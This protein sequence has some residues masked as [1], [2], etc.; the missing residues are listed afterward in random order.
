MAA[1]T[2][3][4]IPCEFITGH[5]QLEINTNHGNRYQIIV[6][7]LINELFTLS[8]PQRNILF[9]CLISAKQVPPKVNLMPQAPPSLLCPH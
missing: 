8:T 4:M 7:R 5:I 2:C 1:M 6:Y 9:L 3:S